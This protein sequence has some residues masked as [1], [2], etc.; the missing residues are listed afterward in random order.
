M[1]EDNIF[2]ELKAKAKPNSYTKAAIT[3]IEKEI[4]V[5]DELGKLSPI[6]TTKTHISK[7]NWKKK[8]NDL[9][10]ELIT[11]EQEN[12]QLKERTTDMDNKTLAEF[13]TVINSLHVNHNKSQMAQ[14]DELVGSHSVIAVRKSIV[15]RIT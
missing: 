2:K 1:N 12:L 13:M 9:K 10:T 5:P 11:L 7:T 6:N 3:A 4:P 15:E 14:L 8:Y